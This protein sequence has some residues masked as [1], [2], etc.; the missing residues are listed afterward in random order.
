MIGD[1]AK[2]SLIFRSP[3]ICCFSPQ[4]RPQEGMG[5]HAPSPSKGDNR[6]GCSPSRTLG[7]LLTSSLSLA[8]PFFSTTAATLLSGASVLASAGAEKKTRERQR[9]RQKAA[10]NR[11]GSTS[12]H[13]HNKHGK[14]N[15]PI[16]RRGHRHAKNS[17]QG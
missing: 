15:Q 1:R 8:L 9:Q 3:A 4:P 17:V 10:D 11:V 2:E 16:D 6:A 13:A 12:L 7:M 5:K 14:T